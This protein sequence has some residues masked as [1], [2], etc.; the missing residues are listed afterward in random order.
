MGES[1]RGTARHNHLPPLTPPACAIRPAS[2]R[3]SWFSGPPG[4]QPARP[5]CR[6]HAYREVAWDALTG[7]DVCFPILRPAEGGRTR[8]ARRVHTWEQRVVC[9]ARRDPTS[10]AEGI[11]RDVSVAPSQ[12]RRPG[13]QMCVPACHGVKEPATWPCVAKNPNKFRSYDR[14]RCSSVAGILSAEEPVRSWNRV[15]GQ[16]QVFRLRPA[17]AGNFDQG[18]KHGEEAHNRKDSHW[19]ACTGGDCRRPR[20]SGRG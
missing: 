3:G 9:A 20:S 17:S 5:G 6:P 19:C 10:R 18:A 2:P 13:K 7:A 15:V 12:R 8:R 14:L 16:G 1:P 4:G 11:G